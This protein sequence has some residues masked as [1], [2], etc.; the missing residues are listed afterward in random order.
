MCKLNP[1]EYYRLTIYT[2]VNIYLVSWDQN[3]PGELISYPINS[4]MTSIR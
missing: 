2:K 4:H 3:E 1:L